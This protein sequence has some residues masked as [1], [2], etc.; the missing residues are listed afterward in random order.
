MAGDDLAG[1]VAVLHADDG[2]G[3]HHVVVDELPDRIRAIGDPLL[4]RVDQ[5]L[6][7]VDR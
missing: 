7:V 2:V 3:D 1:V 5:R 6:H 4:V